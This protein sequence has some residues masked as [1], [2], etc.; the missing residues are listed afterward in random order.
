MNEKKITCPSC[1]TEI[2]VDQLIYDS[3]NEEIEKKYSDKFL[4]KKATLQ[5]ESNSLNK[6]REE[7]ESDKEAQTLIIS[8][9]IKKGT[10]A[11]EDKLRTKIKTDLKEE[12]SDLIESMKLELKEKSTKLK[13]FNKAKGDIERLKREKN[14]IKDAI[15]AES[16][17]KLNE[18]IS[19]ER[20]KI[21][22]LEEEKSQL[23][24]L[25][26]ESI[27]GQLNGQLKDALRQ[28]EQGSMQRQ[29]EVQEV[30]IENWLAEH[31]PLD[32][33][34]GI[35]KGARGADCLQTVNSRDRQGCGTIY[36]ESKRTKEFQPGWIEKFKSDIQ[37]KNADIGVLVTESIPSDMDR[38][39]LRDGIW[40][41]TFEEFKGFSTVLR[42]SV[43]KLSAAVN[44]QE[45][46]GE[47][48]VMLYDFLTGNEFKMQIEGIV[49][50]FT[51]MHSDLESEKRSMT[52][53]WK[54]REKQ[55]AKVIL[56]TNYMYNSVKG[57]AGSVVP[58]VS[59]LELPAAEED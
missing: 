22:K 20:G 32:T 2:N 33:I 30:A 46:R 14:E 51:Q 9:A 7:F 4:K 59:L 49:E 18:K 53:I 29:G 55:I 17:K 37:E 1:K 6:Q 44:M 19:E 48:M 56:N 31:F 43:L 38:I 12:Q 34:E 23:Q 21:K 50:G 25:E 15:E 5:T 3:L 28:A 41:C 54:K 57:I 16:E 45:N 42:E 40:V 35:K 36:Y 39:G 58:T 8:S 27:I 52:G 11:L 24:I 10:K 26:K 13:D 47:K